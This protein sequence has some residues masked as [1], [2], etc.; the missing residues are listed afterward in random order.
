MRRILILT[1]LL[2]LTA[3]ATPC[4][5][6]APRYAYP[7]RNVAGLYS[8]NFGE[9][10][11]GHFH[12]GIDIKTDGAEGRPV[13]AV[14]D[15]SIT[16]ITLTPGGYGRALYLTLDD[17]RTAVYG[18][19]SRFRDDLEQRL[20]ADRRQRRSNTADLWFRVGELPVSR[21]EVIAYSGNSGS[22]FGPH[23]HFELRER[24]TGRRLNVVREGVVRPA[25]TIPPTIVRV[26]YIEVDTVQGVPVRGARRSYEAVRE[27]TGRYRLA[28]DG[29]VAAGRRGYFILEATDRRNGVQNTFGLYRASLDIDGIRCFEYRMDGFAYE[30]ARCC[31]AVACYPLQVASRNE[32]LRL[33]RLEKAPECFYPTLRERG[34][35][36]TERDEVRHIRIEAEDDCGNLSQLEFDIRGRA[37]SFR[38]EADTTALV[39]SPDRPAV[40]RIGAAFTARIPAGALYETQYCRPGQCTLRPADACG[41]ALLSPFYRV[42]DASTPLRRE[43]AV[44]LRLFVPQTLERHTALAVVTRKGKLA[45]LGGRYEQGVL[46]ARTRTTGAWV[47]VA[48][49]V[50]PTLAPL[51][52]EGARLAPGTRLRFRAGDN[53]SGIAACTLHIDGEWVP[54]DRFPV[55]G[56]LEYLLPPQTAPGRH[57]VRLEI[58]DGC[59]NDT[60]WEGSFYV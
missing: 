53:F 45:C 37:S 20:G 9:M 27:R 23:L 38:A 39:V 24:G 57:T 21:G 35:I 50:A 60:V 29:P 3:H 2:G 46:T 16:R 54:C 31:D 12:S 58:R 7:V 43:A 17:G 15:G 26:H 51:F 10:R 34:L 8:A 6:E 36:R 59:G 13:V 5:A 30:H 14:T 19:L 55:R 25:D 32:V 44:A 41:V 11:P 28:A 40:L 49:T 56:T 22:S 1:C 18:H 48:D 47:A 4:R 52:R 42:F 33:A